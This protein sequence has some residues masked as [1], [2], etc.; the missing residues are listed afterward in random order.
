MYPLPFRRRAIGSVCGRAVL[1]LAVLLAPGLTAGGKG[2]DI[3][4]SRPLGMQ[5]EATPTSPQE[6]QVSGRAGTR[7]LSDILSRIGRAAGVTVLADSTVADERVPSPGP[8]MRVSA[9]SI[10][11]RI[12]EV[13]KT[14]PEGVLWA[15]LYLPPPPPGRRWTGDMVAAYAVAQANLYGRA[16]SATPPGTVEIISQEVPAEKAASVVSALNLK[17][18]Y[19]VT[20]RGGSG[21]TYTGTWETT[22]GTMRLRQV[23]RRV[24]GT[25]TSN[26]GE[27]E[28][29]VRGRILRYYW[30]ENGR[31]SRGSGIF[32]LGDD[33]KSFSGHWN[34]VDNPDAPGSQW[35]GTRTGW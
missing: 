35:T 21:G 29:E 33:G 30:Y 14:L 19:L 6:Q 7:P 17:P 20:R 1:A 9:E 4:I 2:Q 16:G 25:Y 26:N 12:A 10:E 23:G 13:I 8:E 3:T 34:N 11:A 22:F 27:I 32:T 18:V 15:K 28:G 5:R 24:T 31:S